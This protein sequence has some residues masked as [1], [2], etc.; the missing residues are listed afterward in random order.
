M[1]QRNEDTIVIRFPGAPKGTRSVE[2]AAT[3][4]AECIEAHRNGADLSDLLGGYPERREVEALIDVADLVARSGADARATVGP[5]TPMPLRAGPFLP[6]S[7]RSWPSP[8]VVAAP[9]GVLYGTNAIL[10]PA[11][12]TPVSL[13][14]LAMIGWLACCALQYA[15]KRPPALADLR[16]SYRAS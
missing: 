6:K 7:R 1:N 13:I 12:S 14:S 15:R 16:R 5:A 2:G 3:V 8:L 10:A 9:W 4:L 11:G